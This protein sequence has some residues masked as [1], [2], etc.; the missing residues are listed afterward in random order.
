M[1][2]NEGWTATCNLFSL[3]RSSFPEKTEV[4]CDS[5]AKSRAENCV[6]NYM[7]DKIG[8]ADSGIITIDQSAGL[9]R[10]NII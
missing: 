2:P 9:A 7:S 10:E 1:T 4:N 5:G 3:H 6:K 8:A